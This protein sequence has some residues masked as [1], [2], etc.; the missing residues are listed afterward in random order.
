MT[1]YEA[2]RNRGLLVPEGMKPYYR[3]TY[4]RSRYEKRTVVFR[5]SHW[6]VAK[7]ELRQQW[8]RFTELQ[9][10]PTDCVLDIHCISEEMA[11]RA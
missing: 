4:G 8:E 11:V 2:F 1:I 7:E 10:I 3:I 9:H 6:N 5:T